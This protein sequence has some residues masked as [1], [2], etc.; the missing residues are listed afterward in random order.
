MKIVLNADLQP[1]V[2]IGRDEV[3]A[4]Y[5]AGGHVDFNNQFL[6]DMREIAAPVDPTERWPKPDAKVV[7]GIG[8]HE[9]TQKGFANVVAEAYSSHHGLVLH[10]HDIWYVVLSN[11]AAVVGANPK[12]YQG[13]YTVSD[14]KQMLLVEQD[15]ATDI[16]IEAL[17]AKLREVMPVDVSV[18]LP[19]L[20]TATPAANTAMAAAVLD[21]AKHFY[22]YGMFCCGIPFIDLHGTKAEWRSLFHAATTIVE[23][24]L[25]LETAYSARPL[26]S[27][28]LG[29]QGVLIDI[30]GSFDEDKT[31]FWKDIFTKENVGS[32]GDLKITG[33]ICKLYHN[34]KQGSLIRSFHDAV[35]SFTYKNV[36]TGEHFM[37]FHGAFGSNVVDGALEIAY[38]HVTVQYKPKD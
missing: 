11:I 14:S 1:I 26:V 25:K 30:M 16:N 8:D 38:D 36:T 35:S 9:R 24:T 23:E 7:R 2:N 5:R 13:L 18:F 31:E 17:I 22:D 6:Y 28:M 21:A 12:A 37:Q 29:V 34:A 19:E 27:Y 4:E 3:R 15:H 32:G 33:W 10:P 20:S